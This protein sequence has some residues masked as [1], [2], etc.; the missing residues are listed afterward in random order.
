MI[1]ALEEK[2]IFFYEIIF[3]GKATLKAHKSSHVED[4]IVCHIFC[5]IDHV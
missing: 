4:N 5:H 2:Q 1:A 3:I